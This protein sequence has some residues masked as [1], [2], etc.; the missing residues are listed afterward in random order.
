MLIDETAYPIEA[1]WTGALET[2]AVS[3]S[4]GA[5]TLPQVSLGQPVWWTDPRKLGAD[6]VP[7][8][9]GQRYIMARFSYTLSPGEP[10]RFESVDL[11]LS[12]T[13]PGS[14]QRPIAY[15]LIPGLTTED[16]TGKGKFTL[17]PKL[18]FA[19]VVEFSGVQAG[20]EIDLKRAHVVSSIYGLGESD[21]RWE[22]KARPGHPLVGSQTVF[23]VLEVPA[24]AQTTRARV[25]LSAQVEVPLWGKV[26]GQLPEE[27]QTQAQ[28]FAPD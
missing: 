3:F 21:A 5:G 1:A 15:D 10:Q 18:K 25:H 13:A 19:N 20:V 14:A 27:A 8:A 28:F 11:T 24:G 23:V 2:S 7:P 12:F 4:K 9:G 22:F 6:W 26:R 16:Q 17:D